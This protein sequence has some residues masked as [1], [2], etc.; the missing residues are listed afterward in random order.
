MPGK[1][2]RHN[3][4]GT[5]YQRKSDDK[6][7]ASLTLANGKRKVLYG[8]TSDDVRRQLAKAVRERDQGI[9]AHSDER[10]TVAAY[11]AGWNAGRRAGARPHM[12][13]TPSRSCM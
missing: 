6:W 10:L 7:C 11:L 12:S 1:R 4:E 13:A 3:G 5:I 8:D 9:T 2:G